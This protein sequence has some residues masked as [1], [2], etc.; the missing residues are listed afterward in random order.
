MRLLRALIGMSL[1]IALCVTS[2]ALA[3][4]QKVILMLGGKF[5]DMYK[6]EVESAL[7]KAAGVTAVDLKSMKGHA[8]VAG[9]A[10][11]MKTNELTA[12]I[13]ALKGEG[14]NCTAEVMK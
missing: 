6:G 13:N 8:I 1:G 4:E 12:A 5:C 14:W 2:T 11:K 10:V 3:A 7:K 9:D